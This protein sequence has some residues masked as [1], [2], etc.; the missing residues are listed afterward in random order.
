VKFLLDNAFQTP[1][2]MIKPEII[3]L[4]QPTGAIARVRTAQD[5]APRQGVQ[6]HLAGV[7]R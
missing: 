6:E 3:R 1:Q 2:F 5:V 7:Q 4:M